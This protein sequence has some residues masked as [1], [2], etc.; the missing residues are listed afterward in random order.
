MKKGKQQREDTLEAW[1]NEDPKLSDSMV[2][3][4]TLKKHRASWI[5]GGVIAVCLAVF[6]IFKLIAK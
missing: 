3:G 2:Y 6:V 1:T 4:S 5:I